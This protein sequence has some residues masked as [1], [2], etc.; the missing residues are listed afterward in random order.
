MILIL[1]GPPA[2]GKNT[3]GAHIASR[4]ER[5]ALIDV[6][7]LRLMVAR[8][9]ALPWD[10]AE[11]A[12]QLRLSVHNA[13]HLARSFV[14]AGYRVVILDV[15]TAETACAYHL[16]L[17]EL[18]HVI[19]Q[20]LP[21]FEEVRRRV[22]ARAKRLSDAELRLLYGWQEA[23]TACDQRIDNSDRP[24]HLLAAQLVASVFGSND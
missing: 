20:L 22:Q 6:D 13:A 18:D 17:D 10:G 15:L 3:V 8:S 7:L 14:G 11:G 5:C 19:V 1:T 4:L 24:A 16:L 9:F 21:P 2:A 23:L 12:A